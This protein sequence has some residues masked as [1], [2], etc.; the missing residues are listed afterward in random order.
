MFV[1]LVLSH[2]SCMHLCAYT[3]VNT[4][5]HLIL[6]VND[7]LYTSKLK[8]IVNFKKGI[9]IERYTQFATVTLIYEKST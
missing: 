7:G 4:V 8:E 6:K 9:G 1:L 2:Q 3:H 5:F